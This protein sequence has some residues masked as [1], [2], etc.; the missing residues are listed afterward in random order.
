MLSRIRS[1]KFFTLLQPLYHFLWAFFS[2][3]YYR[4]PA[5]SLVVIGITGTKGK[6]STAEFLNAILEAQGF[7]TAL[8][9][10]IRFKIGDSSRPNMFKMSMPGRGF[11]QHFL[12][13][14][15]RAGCTHAIIEMTSEGMRQDRHRF[16]PLDG[17][18]FLNIT[19]EHIESHDSFE[20]YLSAKLKI[21]T[22]LA[23]SYKKKKFIV[24]NVTNSYAERFLDVRDAQRIAYSLEDGVPWHTSEEGIS[25][26]FKNTLITSPLKG[27]FMIENALAACCA[28]DALGIPHHIIAQGISS[29]SVI[30][31]RAQEVRLKESHPHVNAQDFTV[32]VDYA[33]T[34]ESLEAIY[35]AYEGKRRI[36]VL[37]NTGGGRDTW[38]R[39][40][41][42]MV[43]DTYCDEIILTNEDPYDEDPRKIVD[44]MA[45]GM[46]KNTPRILMDRREAIHTALTL[47]HPHDVVIITGKGT[48]PYIMEAHG[49]KTP[50]SDYQVAYEELE[51]VIQD[52]HLQKNTDL[53][54]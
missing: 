30:P 3:L 40:V 45:Q 13:D 4:F 46:K 49:K 19:P 29:L 8:L 11:V 26:T 42:G 37:G 25:F 12:R 14:A 16:I 23:S 31:G 10:T 9:G 33:H 32:V 38:K 1:T 17:A 6:S 41:M 36:C 7:T 51:K 22:A 21:R 47:A 52:R 54:V 43:A 53:A 28:A 44:A 50:W 2:A 35:R 39:P 34:K 24:A 20:N 15:V 5:R 18:I 27:S 48:D